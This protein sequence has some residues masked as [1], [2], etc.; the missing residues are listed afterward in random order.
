MSNPEE[1]PQVETMYDALKARNPQLFLD[2]PLDPFLPKTQVE[3]DAA[4]HNALAII[5]CHGGVDNAQHLEWVVDQVARQLTT[6]NYPE[7]VKAM[8]DG[9]EGPETFSW[10]KGIHP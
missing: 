6:T 4:C 10:S 9:D 8:R 2:F 3:L 7:F 5:A 1:E